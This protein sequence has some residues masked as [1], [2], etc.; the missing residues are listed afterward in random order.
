MGWRDNGCWRLSSV[1]Y[2]TVVLV[3]H[4]R[5]G[6]GAM[7]AIVKRRYTLAEYRELDTHADE[8]YE[9]FDGEVAA[10][11]GASLRRNRIV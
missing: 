7:S 5:E 11:R 1:C 8:R 9:D 2:A 3:Q 6:V 4:R 10:M